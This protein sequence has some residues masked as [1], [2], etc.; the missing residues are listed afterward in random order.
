MYV[1]VKMESQYPRL[2]EATKH[3]IIP[4]AS[5]QKRC[6]K[7]CKRNKNSISPI[8]HM[9]VSCKIL[10]VDLCKAI[11]DKIGN[12]L[13]DSVN[14]IVVDPLNPIIGGIGY[15]I[16]E[17]ES[18]WDCVKDDIGELIDDIGILNQI[19][20]MN[21]FAYFQGWIKAV[22]GLTTTIVFWIALI[23]IIFFLLATFGGFLS[24]I[25]LFI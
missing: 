21:I 15:E 1:C 12:P 13:I 6:G 9:D 17:I 3:S 2:R 10:G 11:L 18:W 19:L 14:K 22:T 16:C 4:G 23:I 20:D 8:P 25:Q 7:T 5:P 24:L